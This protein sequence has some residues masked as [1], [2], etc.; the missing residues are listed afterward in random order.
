V[1]ETCCHI[2]EPIALAF[3]R[4][5]CTICDQTGYKGKSGAIVLHREQS[6]A[7][8]RLPTPYSARPHKPRGGRIAPKPRGG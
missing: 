4:Y 2:W 8:D 6:E 5:R 3:N 1:T 7:A